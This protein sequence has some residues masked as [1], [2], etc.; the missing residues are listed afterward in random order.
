MTQITSLSNLSSI[1]TSI[2]NLMLLERRPITRLEGKRGDLQTLNAVYSDLKSKLVTL[3]SIAQDLAE[4]IDSPLAARSVASSDEDVVMASATSATALGSHQI[5]VSQ[6][7]KHHTMV[8]DRFT[9]SD[10]SIRTSRPPPRSLSGATARAFPTR[11]TSPTSAG[12]SSRS[13]ASMM[14]LNWPLTP[15]AVTYTPIPN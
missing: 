6:L 9:S 3:R 10:N 7:A 8:S 14:N 12:A 15:R 1:Y 2:S 11:R 5:F 4:T 13:L